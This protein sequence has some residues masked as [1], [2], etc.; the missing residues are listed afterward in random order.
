MSLHWKVLIIKFRI[1]SIR[2]L[3]IIN[4]PLNFVENPI[5]S[6]ERLIDNTLKDKLN[7]NF[8]KE[9][10]LLLIE[11]ASKHK[12]D[13][14]IKQPINVINQTKEYFDENDP[15]KIWLHSYYD[16]T[17]ND[18]DRISS[19]DLYNSYIYD[20]NLKISIVK[21][22]E[23]MKYNEIEFIKPK[24]KTVYIKIK[25]KDTDSDN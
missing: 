16:L 12:Y 5:K 3:K 25:R 21:F 19:S 24:N 14:I 8:Y 23:Y 17:D 11:I 22:S 18:K 4:F 10:I 7:N 9:L 13:N 20:G 15:I 1:G 2:R 6:N